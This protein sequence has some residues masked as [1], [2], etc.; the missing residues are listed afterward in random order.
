MPATNPYLAMAQPILDM[1]GLSKTTADVVK[2]PPK[3]K[4]ASNG[5]KNLISDILNSKTFWDP[6]VINDRINSVKTPS[7]QMG[8]DVL[9]ALKPTIAQM[10][11]PETQ[12]QSNI[13]PILGAN[14]LWNNKNDLRNYKTPKDLQEERTKRALAATDDYLK[15]IKSV[16]DLEG[17]LIGQQLVA[18]TGSAINKKENTVGTGKGSDGKKFQYD[19]NN[20]SN[21]MEQADNVV[22]Q[23]VSEGFNPSSTFSAMSGW[24][25]NILT[26]EKQQSYD[27]AKLNFVL[28]YLRYT[29]GAQINA[30]EYSS[31]YKKFFPSM[32]DSPAVIAQ[33][34]AARQQAIASIRATAGNV[35]DES[36]KV[37]VVRH[38][39]P[40]A[41]SSRMKLSPAEIK[42]MADLQRKEKERKAGGK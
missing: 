24:I 33:K 39:K 18:T 28:N 12:G 16:G 30:S 40:T 38:A 14:D 26:P 19:A 37:S 9:S 8:E 1:F 36:A 32:G 25:P 35:S 27:A 42:E 4:P 23:L 22:N 7:I 41:P 2:D 29:S 5:N 3:D 21:S 15:Q 34:A 6:E 11:A 20:V 13:A 10:Y 17:N 31:E